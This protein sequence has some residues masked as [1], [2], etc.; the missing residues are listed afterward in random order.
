MKIMYAGVAGKPLQGK[1][2][3]FKMACSADLFPCPLDFTDSAACLLLELR[4][5]GP[6]DTGNRICQRYFWRF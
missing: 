3:I 6:A 5:P 2:C 4:M 1:G